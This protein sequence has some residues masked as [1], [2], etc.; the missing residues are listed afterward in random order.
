MLTLSSRKTLVAAT[1]LV[2]LAGF[3]IVSY[4]WWSP[5]ERFATQR[6]VS[7]EKGEP[8][9]RISRKLA[10]AGVVRSAWALK[11]YGHLSGTARR[12][13]PGDYAFKGGERISDVMG[14]LVR[15]D[16]MIVTVTIPEGLTV[17]QIAE[18]VAGAGLVC[19]E[20]FERAARDGKLVRAL[21][22][23]PLGAEGYLFPATY[24]FSPHATIDQVLAAMLTRFYRVLTPAVEERMFELDLTPRELVTMAS[25]VEKEAKAPEERPVIAG[26]FY[27]RLRLKM[28]L[29][30]DPTAE[31]RLSG[32][33]SDSA[34]S[35]VH[36]ESAFNTYDFA[37][38]PPGPIANPG[39]KSIEAALH[40]QQTD[41][42]YFVARDDG[43]HEFSKSFDQHRRAIAS[44]RKASAQSGAVERR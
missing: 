28:P 5:T 36:T 40:P 24:R 35:A 11:L 32:D 37:G 13:K 25:I 39:L 43:T 22:L 6:E 42:L 16:F 38:L 27:N 33:E 1:A 30:S 23:R 7:I 29:Q 34:V 31:Y 44:I 41:F 19:Q 21:G 17:H 4:C 26:V 14:H 10:D 15:G 3:A 8:F 2:A 12:I 20:E 18:K 9:A